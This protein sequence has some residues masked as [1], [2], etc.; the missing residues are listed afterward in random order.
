MRV[1]IVAFLH[2][3]NTFLKQPTTVESFRQNLLCTGEAVREALA[4]AHHEVGGFFAGLADAD[5]EAVPLFAARALPSGTIAASDFDDLV[6]QL[7]KSVRKS[8]RLDGI[9][10]APHGATVSENQPDADGYWLH[11]LRQLVGSTLPIIGTL[12]AHA[13][14]SPLM[15]DSCDALVAYRTNPHLDQRD[16]GIEAAQLMAKTVRQEIRPTM[17]AAF[18]PM[19]ISIERQCTDEP[20][21]TPLYAAANQQL[22]TGEAASN[23]ILLG[24]PY[25]DVPEMGSAVIA[26]TDNDPAKAQRLADQLAEKMWSMRADLRGEFTSVTQALDECE[27]A[28]GRVC[29]LDMGDNVGGGSSA[30]GTELLGEIHRR[31]AGPAFGCL[32]DPEAVAACDAA[33]EGARLDLKVGGKTDDLHGAPIAVTVTVK[34]MHDGRFSEPQPRHGGITEFDQGR[35]AICETD[36]GLTLMLTSRRMVPFSLQQI[37]SCG[38]D[39]KSFRLLVAKGVNAPIAAYREVCDSFIRVNTIGATCADMNRLTYHHRRQPLFPL[40]PNTEFK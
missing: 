37:V 38:L 7:L 14:L 20:H 18:P 16:R 21:L 32:F 36:G 33:S 11:Q 30:D 9:L 15:V 40:E 1:G 22:E 5:I 29:L 6:N 26:V 25:S 27:S 28:E 3:S 8:E 19:A 39:P 10:V 4:E 12:D 13:N 17:A 34:S 31:E 35:T 2:E 23:S 24:F